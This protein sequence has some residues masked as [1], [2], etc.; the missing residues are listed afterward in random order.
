MEDK[1]YRNVLADLR[2][3]FNGGSIV[4]ASDVAAY[5]GLCRQTAAK[6]YDIPRS[7]IALPILARKMCEE[8]VSRK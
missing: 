8:K 5:T 6:R 7:G 1:D 2:G 3:F 4:T